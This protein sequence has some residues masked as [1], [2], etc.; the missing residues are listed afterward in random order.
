[1]H[2]TIE[3]ECMYVCLSE[4]VSVYEIEIEKKK[5]LTFLMETFL[6]SRQSNQTKPNQT[7]KKLQ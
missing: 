3:I 1:M 6:I 5:S 2:K 4:W 7:K